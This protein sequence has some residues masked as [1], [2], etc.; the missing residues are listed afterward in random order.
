MAEALLEVDDLHTHFHLKNKV[1]RAVNGVS[2]SVRRGEI[3]GIA[4]ESGAGKSV[5]CLSILRLV[6]NPGRIE[7]GRILFTGEDLLGKTERQ[8]RELRGQTVS[9]GVRGSAELPRPRLHGR[10]SDRRGADPPQGPVE[11]G[12]VEEVR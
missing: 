6:P 10:R 8:M 4:G 3:V 11:A 9:H 5:A 12:G 7:R 1:V 2:F